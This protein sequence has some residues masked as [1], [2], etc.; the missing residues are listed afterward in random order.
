MHGSSDF[1]LILYFMN[2]P[3]LYIVVPVVHLYQGTYHIYTRSCPALVVSILPISTPTGFCE[4]CYS[5]I[6]ALILILVD[7]RERGEIGEK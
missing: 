6:C 5:K 3:D 2:A 7:E 4:E 1:I